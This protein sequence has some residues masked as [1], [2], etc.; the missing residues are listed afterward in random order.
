MIKICILVSNSL[1]KDPRVIKQIKCAL[2][3]GF[4]VNFI[5]LRDPK[6]SKTFLENVG[7][8]IQMIDLGDSYVGHLK[9]VFK[10][11]YR[12]WMQFYLPIKWITKINPDVIHANDF[13]TL[14]QSFIASKLCRAKVLYDSHEI[15]AENIGVSNNKIH[16]KIIIFF[17]RLLVGKV[18]AMVSVSNAAAQYFSDTYN[19]SKP[20]V[21]TNCPYRENSKILVHKKN[22]EFEVIY[23]GLMIKG[24]GYEE[25]VQSAK[26]LND[27]IKLVLRGYGSIEYALK[28]IITD[29]N[30][31]NKVR[32]DGPVE[33]K[34]I[35]QK[36]SE[37]NLG[38]V[39]TQPV[40]INF[41]YTVSNKIFEYIQAG[42]PVLMSDIPEH[43]FLNKEFNFGIIVTDF[44]PENIAKTIN[45]IAADQD[46][47]NLLRKN[48]NEAAKLLC[49]EN[50]SR[51][52]ISLYRE[53]AS[54]NPSFK[55][56][57]KNHINNFT[58]V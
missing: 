38:V 3:E 15:C 7:C 28:K 21:I 55:T 46:K 40:N 41:K 16:K 44:S 19:I 52:L 58:N 43:R 22:E 50:E 4:E 12:K 10:K 8:N 11:L 56:D 48:A 53:L 31:N 2:E 27:K 51:K 18:G 14:L 30:L 20:V 23:Q 34:D 45:E 24:R 36:A 54:K 39:L 33:I 29:N 25:F 1:R 6:Y 47:Y 9:S 5:G 32:F 35:V 49:W 17:E 26:Y 57:N 13:D 37:S 42:L